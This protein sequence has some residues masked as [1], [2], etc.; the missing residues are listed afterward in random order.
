MSPLFAFNIFGLGPMELLVIAILGVLLFGRKLP[1]ISKYLG[2]SIIEFKKGMKGLEDH[3]D[4]GYAPSH[5]QPGAAQHPQAT[6]AIRPPQR[7]VATAPKFED[8]PAPNT[9]VT[10]NPP[11]V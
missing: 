6:E 8:A 3:I 10:N 5:T 7:V 4:D 9:H 1:E 2:K 11:Q